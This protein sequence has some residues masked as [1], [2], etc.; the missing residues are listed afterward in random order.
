MDDHKEN[1]FEETNY[2]K[3][4]IG[5]KA[6]K[7]GSKLDPIDNLSFSDHREEPSHVR[8]GSIRVGGVHPAWTAEKRRA[9][10]NGGVQRM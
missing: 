1:P 5:K 4:R 8:S 10:T 3:V 9:R 6:Y 7:S 2:V